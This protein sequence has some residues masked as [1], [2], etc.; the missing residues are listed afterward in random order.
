MASKGKAQRPLV[1]VVGGWMW[2]CGNVVL[3]V[4]FSC[5]LFYLLVLICF[6]VLFSFFV[7]VFDVFLGFNGL[8]KMWG[9]GWGV[10]FCFFCVSV[11]CFW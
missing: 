3:G 9:I 11:L 8:M 6:N 10:A 7:T 5:F 1:S 2:G 4:V